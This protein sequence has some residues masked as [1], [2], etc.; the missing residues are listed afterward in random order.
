MDRIRRSY[1]TV[2]A[3]YA[4]ELSGELAAKPIDRALLAALVELAAERAAAE[5]GAVTGPGAAAE[6]DVVTEP[7]AVSEPPV[8]R[9][10]VIADIGCGPGHITAHLAG[11]GA[12]AFGVDLSPGM[13]TEAKRRH[14]HLAFVAGSLLALPVRTGAVEAVVCA[15]TI[16][17]L[18]RDER[19][20]AFAELA[21]VI[22]PGGWLLLSFHVGAEVRHLDTWW[23]LDVD[24]DFRFLDPDEVVADLDRFTVM[25]R[26]EREPW[27]GVEVATRRCYLLARR[28]P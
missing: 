16:I 22:R 17:H 24:L 21:R 28:D 8:P 10:P 5:P 23:D 11:L 25:A 7:G 20:R 18:D 2:A 6:P 13:V 3:R 9:P 19:R 12:R 27:P 26:T 4:E 1:D 14:P 15:Y